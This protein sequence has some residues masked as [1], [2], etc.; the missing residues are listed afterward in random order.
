MENIE[1][2]IKELF[3]KLFDMKPEEVTLKAN[4]NDD[5]GMDSTEM[6]ELIVALE[7]EFKIGIEDG[8]I[9]NKHCV[10]DVVRIVEDKLKQ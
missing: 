1:K 5:L 4:L 2:R 3:V 6:V 10:S 8:E 7:K 9:T